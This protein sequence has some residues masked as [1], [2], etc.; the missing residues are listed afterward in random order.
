MCL[1][2]LYSKTYQNIL[3]LPWFWDFTLAYTWLQHQFVLIV[4]TLPVTLDVSDIKAES[5]ESEDDDDEKQLKASKRK[6]QT[7]FFDTMTD[8]LKKFKTADSTEEKEQ[9]AKH[10]TLLAD[11][12]TKLKDVLNG[13]IILILEFEVLPALTCFWALYQA[14]IFQN[15]LQTEYITPKLLKVWGLTHAFLS[16]EIS[17]EDYEK[18]YQQLTK[19]T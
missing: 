9:S 3:Y 6:F 14:G 18:C 8:S 4:V 5:K 2:C 16:V 13:S 1:Y 19:S 12:G 17:T 10:L 11:V 15:M 7:A